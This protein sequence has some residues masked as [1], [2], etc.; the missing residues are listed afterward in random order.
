MT[1]HALGIVL[2][3][4]WNTLRD[5]WDMDDQIDGETGLHLAIRYQNQSVAIFLLN[6]WANWQLKTDNGLDCHD[7][8]R[9]C[10]LNS[11]CIRIQELY[12]EMF[13]M[14]IKPLDTFRSP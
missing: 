9:V 1:V 13:Q 5:D 2:G 8:A 4:L 12:P 3:N 7:L 10:E 14:G 6:M 11:V